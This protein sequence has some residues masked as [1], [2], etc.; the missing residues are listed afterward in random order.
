MCAVLKAFRKKNIYKMV[1]FKMFL[2]CFYLFFLQ[3]RGSDKK[4]VQRMR[5]LPEGNGA[6]VC[7]FFNDRSNPAEFEGLKAGDTCWRSFSAYV[8]I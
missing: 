8:S 1:P 5:I 3:E 7:F 6:R 4:T 2:S